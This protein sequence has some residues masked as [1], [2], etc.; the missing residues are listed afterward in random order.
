MGRY[1]TSLRG[2]EVLVRPNLAYN[3]ISALCFG[4]AAAYCSL[5]MRLLK[6]WGDI[7]I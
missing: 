2:R 7:G 5:K 3:S 1:I 4:V 6:N